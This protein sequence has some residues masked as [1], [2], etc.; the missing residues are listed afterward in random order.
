MDAK[1][2]SWARSVK[3]CRRHAV[4][5]P[6]P[7]WLFTDA[8]RLPNPLATVA[9]LPAGLA[10]VVFRH[11]AAPGRAA[12]AKSVARLC[13]AR[14]LAL[15]IAGDWRLAFTL[16]AG[17]HLRGGRRQPRKT[18]HRITTSSAHTVAELQ[19]ASRIGVALVFIS[20]VFPTKS[21]P[22]GA[23]LGPLRWG[24]LAR[25]LCARHPFSAAALGG[26]DGTTAPRL[27]RSFRGAVGAIEALL[28]QGH[29]VP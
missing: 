16:R 9:R 11:D 22:G 2:V 25:R 23:G 7:L 1:L 21:H 24:A 5:A 6:P 26:M 15:V 10:G 17:V 3:S 4:A 20:P 12:L 19:R 28:H 18:K 29:S 27:P 14:R 8:A 13:R